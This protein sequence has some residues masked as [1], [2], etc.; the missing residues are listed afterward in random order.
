MDA[1]ALLIHSNQLSRAGLNHQI[2]KN[3]SSVLV[4]VI[5]D[6]GN[7]KYTGSVAGVRVNLSS[8]KQLKVGSTFVANVTA[9]DGIIFVTPKNQSFINQNSIKLE[10]L[11][12]QQIF[13]LLQNLGLPADG[14]ALSLFQM[15]KQL[16]MKIEPQF[17]G[18]LYH[19]ALKFKG[20]E[21]LAAEILLLLAKKGINAG[22][23]EILELLAFLEAED[24]HNNTFEDGTGDF[25]NGKNLLNQINKKEGAWFIFPFEMLRLSDRAGSGSGSGVNAESDERERLGWGCIKILLD[26]A[27]SIKMLNFNCDYQGRKYFFN[28]NYENKK[29]KKIKCFASDILLENVDG[30]LLSLKKRFLKICDGIEIDWVDKSEIEGFASGGE[31]FYGFDGSV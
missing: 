22:A 29:C 13:T 2:L 19:L 18:K 6:K 14:V 23:D 9:K 17:L 10:V 28:L 27:N 3:G 26:K 16:E 8:E 4:R 12:N 21:K 7:G 31:N 1:N 15:S 11:N 5:D 25:A 20:K 24:N 30:L